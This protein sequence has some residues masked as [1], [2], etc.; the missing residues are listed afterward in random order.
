VIAPSKRWIYSNCEVNPEAEK[1]I[2]KLPGPYTLILKLK[3]KD[4]ISSLVNAGKETL[5]VKMPKHWFTE[6]V[7]ELEVPI[8]TTSVNETGK[9]FM[10]SLENLDQ[11]IQ[12]KT[13]FMI[14]EGEKDNAPS[15]IIDL[16]KSQVKITER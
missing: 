4:A 5:G 1:W 12:K 10:T 7:R 11:N 9:Y 3:N 6:F 14:D 15:K 8:I 2:D 16:T 13:D